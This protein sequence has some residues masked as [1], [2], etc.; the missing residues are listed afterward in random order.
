MKINIVIPQ[1]LTSPTA[2]VCGA[3]IAHH[4]A[5]HGHDVKLILLHHDLRAGDERAI[6]L[7]PNVRAIYAGQMFVRKSGSEKT[8]FPLHKLLRVAVSS[9]RGLIR[10]M[11]RNRADVNVIY[12]SQPPTILA[13]L[14]VR[15]VHRT[16]VVL[17]VDDLE[18]ESNNLHLPGL[19]TL[20]RMFEKIGARR[21]DAIIAQSAYLA[22]YFKRLAGGKTE[23]VFL[24]QGVEP[25]RYKL[26]ET[27]TRALREKYG[28]GGKR[29]AL[30]F[31][32]I[33]PKSGQRVDLLIDA[34]AGV[35]RRLPDAALA[36]AGPGEID[37][38]KEHAR[39]AGV[40]DRVVFTGRFPFEDMPAY[41]SAADVIVDPVD[42]SPVNEAKYSSRVK[43][44]MLFGKPVLT[45]DIGV[46]PWILG[47]GGIAVRPNDVDA[48]EQALY[49]MLLDDDLRAEMGR[50]GRK[51]IMNNFLW[52]QVIDDYIEVLDSVVRGD[53][54]VPRRRL[55]AVRVGQ[56]KVPVGR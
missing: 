12:K 45:G 1:S 47:G 39:K 14:L 17:M 6:Q 43:F 18:S 11:M 33:N 49:L 15:A 29:V 23:T 2:M 9:T 52:E 41:V 36:L 44:G 25:S 30:Y 21:S 22:N 54:R 16:P 55:P 7:E 51:R 56:D 13:G 48:L 34:F 53:D 5:R 32:S 24:P 46:R 10:E 38:M 26:D 8:Y 27:R 4:L 40:I 20:F 50:R 37:R 42:D 3:P 19:R 28:L 35:A 31:G